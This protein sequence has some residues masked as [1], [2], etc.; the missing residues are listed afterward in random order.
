MIWVGRLGPASVAGV[1]IASSAITVAFSALTGLVWG[2]RAVVSR[3]VGARDWEGANHATRQAFVVLAV[4]SVIMSIAGILLT[5]PILSI[6]HVNPDVVAAGSVYLRIQFLG[7][8]TMALRLI[9]EGTMQASGDAMTPMKIG[10]TFRAVHLVLCPTLVFGLGPFPTMGVAGAAVTN[11]V[12]Q[13]LGG[14][15][16][17]WVLFTGRTG[18]RLT[19]NNFRIDFKM[20]WRMLKVGFPNMVTGTQHFLCVLVLT[21]LIAPF[22]TM[23][24]AAHTLW[25]R[26]DQVLVTMGMGVG[27]SAGVLGAQNL[28]ANKPDRAAKSGW[29]A[30]GLDMAI[31]VVGSIAMLLFAEHMVTIFTS[32]P[33]LIK[34]TATFLRISS[35][36]YL[37]LGLNLVFM[38]YLVGVGDTLNAL[39][40]EL[41]RAWVVQISLAFVLSRYTSLGVYGVRWAMVAGFVFGGLVFTLYFRL[42]KWKHRQF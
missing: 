41:I 20:I 17:L 6:F 12:S 31:M 13:G 24:V 42:G 32:D 16:G 30:A 4:C 40:I 37:V 35:A 1:G 33:E 11:V 38:Q 26:L 36:G 7:I 18:L 21:W 9:T 28:G 10:L 22:G 27:A 3:F 15:L 25:Q 19:L 14:I 29:W 39:I 5:G 2:V 34:M 8:I 23:A